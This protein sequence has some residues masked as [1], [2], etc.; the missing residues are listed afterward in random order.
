[1]TLVYLLRCLP[2]PM[3]LSKNTGTCLAVLCCLASL[4][5]QG[6]DRYQQPMVTTLRA[7]DGTLSTVNG[8]LYLV[9]ESGHWRFASASLQ[10]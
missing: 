4:T 6:Y 3:R 7:V 9:S 1:M 8:T 10:P 2:P 5:P